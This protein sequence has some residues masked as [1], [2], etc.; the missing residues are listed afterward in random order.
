[1]GAE[2]ID[3]SEPM[4]MGKMEPRIIGTV[5]KI[6]CDT[7]T[8]LVQGEIGTIDSLPEMP[9]DTVTAVT[10]RKLKDRGLTGLV[11]I[12]PD[13]MLYSRKPMD[14][15]S[16]IATVV[17]T[18]VDILK[19]SVAALVPGWGPEARQKD[20]LNVYPNPVMRGGMMRLAWRGEAGD[21]AVA[22]LN[23]H[24]QITQERM[25]EV[26]GK[27]QV[28]EWAVPNGLAAGVYFLRVTERS[29]SDEVQ[30]SGAKAY[31]VEVLV[32]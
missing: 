13:T 8:I 31:T 11:S 26:S 2:K 7:D 29:S 6:I 20:V 25:I 30:R 3:T 32:Q 5:P 27:G 18:V 21:Y 9:A 22:F 15:V 14:T 19:D 12:L 24:G 16:R 4:I 17:D 23:L 10:I 1:M 28:D